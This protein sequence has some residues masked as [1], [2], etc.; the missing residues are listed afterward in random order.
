MTIFS[1]VQPQKLSNCFE[2]VASS[3]RTA[4]SYDDDDTVAK[5]SAS[6]DG[7]T[8]STDTKTDESS[9]EAPPQLIRKSE[10]GSSSHRNT[11]NN[12]A[13]KKDDAVTKEFDSTTERVSEPM[14]VTDES[15][16][17]SDSAQAP[18]LSSQREDSKPKSSFTPKRN[19]DYH[20]ITL[21]CV[22]FPAVKRRSLLSEIDVP[23]EA[24]NITI[25]LL[26][27]KDPRRRCFHC[28]FTNFPGTN[29]SL[30]SLSPDLLASLFAG[31]FRKKK[32][33][34]RRRRHTNKKA[35][36]Q[37]VETACQSASSNNENSS[38]SA[39]TNLVSSSMCNLKTND[40]VTETVKVPARKKHEQSQDI[41][42]DDDYEDE[43]DDA[44]GNDGDTEV[45]V[46]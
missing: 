29:G 37:F 4:D 24:I 38:S 18:Q 25:T 34:G 27:D 16:N 46:A 22:E 10:E 13:D 39:S 11:H 42:N 45:V 19:V 14:D 41:D 21:P 15:I 2:I 6:V 5:R 12:K 8:N 36:I 9:G 23:I 43:D 20:A 17:F 7:S 28:V 26:N 1:L 35:R 32:Y 40:V 44:M 33:H 30:G 3:L 31:P